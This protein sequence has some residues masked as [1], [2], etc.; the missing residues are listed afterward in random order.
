MFTGRTYMEFSATRLPLQIFKEASSKQALPTKDDP[1]L[2]LS[3]MNSEVHFMHQLLP[4]IKPD[5]LAVRC[6]KELVCS[7]ASLCWDSGRK[8]FFPPV[9]SE[10]GVS[11]G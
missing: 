4:Y 3:I 9:E 10:L 8:G 5:L 11:K 2:G 6:A 1:D 7:P